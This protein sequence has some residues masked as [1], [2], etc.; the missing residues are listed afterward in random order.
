M[1]E[2]RGKRVNAVEA[3]C[4]AGVAG[5]EQGGGAEAGLIGGAESKRKGP[6]PAFLTWLEGPTS[7]ASGL[8]DPD[9]WSADTLSA[10]QF[11]LKKHTKMCV[12]F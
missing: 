8:P 2:A 1:G 5:G 9:F 7:T 4:T 11:S 6:V 12:Y 10:S 3:G